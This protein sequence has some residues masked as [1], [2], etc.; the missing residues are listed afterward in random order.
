MSNR[1]FLHPD[2]G[3]VVSK[4]GKDATNPSLSDEDKIFDSAWLASGQLIMCK[5]VKLTLPGFPHSVNIDTMY[6]KPLGYI[7]HVTALPVI[8]PLFPGNIQYSHAAA[9]NP[10]GSDDGDIALN[11]G[12]LNL[13]GGRSRGSYSNPAW[14][15]A[16]SW[17]ITAMTD[18]V[19]F[20][21]VQT[22]NPSGHPLY[23]KILYSVLGA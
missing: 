20:Q 12:Y 23:F 19:R 4:P 5:I 3:L 16:G 6:P 22:Q 9:L 13:L 7:P 21:S 8:N 14:N 10:F 15:V 17:N 11:G 2:Q 18:R 1:I